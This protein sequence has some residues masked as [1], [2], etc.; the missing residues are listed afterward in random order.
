MQAVVD[1]YRLENGTATD[2]LLCPNTTY[3]FLCEIS[4]DELLL[5]SFDSSGTDVNSF[6]VLSVNAN[7][8]TTSSQSEFNFTA[9][10]SV[11]GLLAAS[12]VM[13][14]STDLSSVELEC[15]DASDG[16]SSSIRTVVKGEYGHLHTITFVNIHNPGVCFSVGR[17]T[18]NRDT[19]V[20][21]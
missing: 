11:N 7:A 15:R 12:A 19:I 20:P 5:E 8:G 9:F 6:T 2:T 16:N 13:K 21:T 18:C 4:G 10:N 3:T 14:A 17:C 1:F